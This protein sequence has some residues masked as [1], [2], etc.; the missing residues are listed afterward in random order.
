MKPAQIP[1]AILWSSLLLVTAT[2][3]ARFERLYAEGY[4]ANC[5]TG[6]LAPPPVK[7]HDSP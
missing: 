5:V 3:A 2:A 7:K 6:V 4:D 1:S